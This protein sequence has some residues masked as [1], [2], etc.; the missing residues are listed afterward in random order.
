MSGFWRSKEGAGSSAGKQ[1][2]PAKA[3]RTATG[4]QKRG[5]SGSGVNSE[6][7]EEKVD[8][9]ARLT[10]ANSHNIAAIMARSF[11]FHLIAA[12]HP[13]PKATNESGNRYN[14][15]VKEKGKGHGL[16]SPHTHAVAACLLTLGELETTPQEEKFVF[17]TFFKAIEDTTQDEGLQRKWIADLFPY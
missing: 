8:A 5:S 3:Q 15:S 12:G 4:A 14:N 17:R 10:L 13:V 9:I 1:M 2:Q 11:I 16:G 6:D 7:L